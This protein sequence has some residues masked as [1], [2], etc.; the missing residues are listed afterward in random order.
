MIKVWAIG[1]HTVVINSTGDKNMKNKNDIKK[2]EGSL[3]SKAAVTC[4]D[5]MEGLGVGVICCLPDED[6]TFL[7][8]NGCYY[9]SIGYKQEEY[10]ESFGSLREYFAGYEEDFAN[11]KK[12]LERLRETGGKGS[13]LSVRMPGKDGSFGR[14]RFSGSLVTAEEEEGPLLQAV[15]TDISRLS[16]EKEEQFSAYKQNQQ[17][18]HW[19]MDTYVGNVYISDMD[20]YEL[21]YLNQHSCDTLGYPLASLIGKKCYEAI[22]GRTSPCPF[23]TND[24][25]REDEFYEWKFYNPALERTFMI[26]DRIINWEGRR[27]RIELSHDMFSTEYK[28]AQKDQ[29]RDAL[30]SSIPGGIF[31]LD[32]RDM[33]TV[34]WYG[35]NFLDMIEYTGEQFQKELG[36]RYDFI[37]PDD[38]NKLDGILQEVKKSGRNTVE[39]LR[40]IT[41]SGGTRILTFTLSYVDEEESWDDIPSFYSLCIDVTAERM[42]QK[43]QRKALEEA[44]DAA[45]VANAAKTNFLSSMSHDIRTPMNAIMGMAVIAQANLY[46]PEKVQDCL[47]KINI[48]SRHLLNLINEVLDMSKIESGKIDLT[49]ETVSFPELLQD[50]MD[51]CRPL[52]AEKH[53]EFMISAAQVKH[54]KVVSDR[55]R[56]Q[57]IFMNLLSNAIKYTP[58]GGTISLRIREMA[59]VVEGR[60]QYEFVI[61]DNGIGISEEFKAHIFEPFSRA[62]DSRI[63]KIQGTGLGMAITDNIVRMMNGTIEV[64]STLGEGSQF[65]VSL[66]LDLCEEEEECDGRLEG[67]P[68][69]VVDDDRIVCESASALLNELGMRGYWVLTGQEA[70]CC[71]V[72]AHET[73]DDF[74]AVILDWKMPGMDGLETVRVIREKLG[75]D[76]PIIIISAYDYSDIEE[77][78][79][80]AGAD[81][82]IT[83]P[84][85]KSK[86]LHVLQLFCQTLNTDTAVVHPFKKGHPSF[87]GKRILLVEDNELNREIAEELLQMQGF[88]VDTVEN[89]RYAAEQFGNSA[90]GTYAC[91]LMDVQMPVM[92]GYEATRA[93]RTMEREDAG[94]IPIIALTANAFAADMGKARSVGMSDYIAKPIDVGNL[95]DTLKRWLR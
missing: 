86:M 74:F 90:P 91:I 2:E 51:M 19:M 43:R 14:F 53:Q 15:F 31:R 39:E 63:S 4:P 11:I 5:I 57:Q 32:G 24:R 7:W 29:E 20:T 28:L 76:V 44:Y 92:N 84:L 72:K 52:I 56:L 64:E 83:K 85:F 65:V 13:E 87:E 94:S 18:F 25:L 89:G 93:I 34:L 82:F 77:E 47:S 81:A 48:S 46:T 6:L 3:F 41:R 30:L 21:L 38:K 59:S 27:A 70:V 17:Y 69:L 50:V 95:T 23:C 16:E 40:I 68:V 73:G 79:K 78:F 67:L 8:G 80:K 36:S 26:K 61:T 42:E 1:L 37:H 35:C 58:E 88:V 66:P 22:Q 12:E 55:G 45:R 9:S 10:T 54:E 75:P 49:C 60:G 62:E 33:S 71:I